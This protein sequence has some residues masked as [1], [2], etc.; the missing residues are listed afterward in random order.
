MW[1]SC[2][3][4]SGSGWY[5]QRSSWDTEIWREVEC[6]FSGPRQERSS[7]TSPCPILRDLE[8]GRPKRRRLTPRQNTK[9]VCSAAKR[10]RHRRQRNA[11]LPTRQSVESSVL[12][13]ANFS[14]PCGNVFEGGA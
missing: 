7:I 9:P 2:Y 1:T 13:Q 8:S 4:F 12:P 14:T 6:C 10:E 5:S 11:Y 3:R